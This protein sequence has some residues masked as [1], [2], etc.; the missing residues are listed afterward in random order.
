MKRAALILLASFCLGLTAPERKIVLDIKNRADSAMKHEAQL[1]SET[2]QAKQAAAQ[3]DA[4]A[5]T[6]GAKSMEADRQAAEQH[7]ELQ[8][9]V[10][11]NKEIE[12]V[13]NRVQGPWW[14]PGLG[15]IIYGFE[16]LAVH[17]L[18]FSAVIA[19]LLIALMVFVPA[20]I[21]FIRA[22]I[23]AI[24]KFLQMLETVI[25]AFWARVAAMFK[26]KPSPPTVAPPPVQPAPLP[27]N[28]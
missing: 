25:G 28:V 4:S 1:Q 14:A 21:P 18:I 6:A 17:V 16:R 12:P 23:G 5:V 8:K 10:D 22:G 7:A 2:D 15:G 13:Y 26:K 9:A 3:S 27:P 11:R 24:F 20:A 19:V